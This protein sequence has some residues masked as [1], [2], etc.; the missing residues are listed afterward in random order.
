ML[1]PKNVISF[2]VDFFN[3]ENLKEIVS[4]TKLHDKMIKRKIRKTGCKQMDS[5]L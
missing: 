1:K 5:N 3:Q 2:A 4:D